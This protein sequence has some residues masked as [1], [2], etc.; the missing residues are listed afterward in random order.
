M[1]CILGSRGS[2]VCTSGGHIKCTIVTEFGCHIHPEKKPVWMSLI[3]T[4][5]CD[6]FVFLGNVM[7]SRKFF[8]E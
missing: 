2:K 5:T 3:K 1:S 4:K 6:N 8:E 7:I